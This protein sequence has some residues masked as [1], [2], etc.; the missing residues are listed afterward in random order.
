MIDT[1]VYS[2]PGIHGPHGPG[3][4]QFP[5]IRDLESLLGSRPEL[6]VR[7]YILKIW[8]ILV[9]KYSPK[10][11][12]PPKFWTRLNIEKMVIGTVCYTLNHSF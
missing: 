7:S 11:G 8:L 2:E 12:F 9:Q 3:T 10:R 5:L 4:D 6:L 1:Q